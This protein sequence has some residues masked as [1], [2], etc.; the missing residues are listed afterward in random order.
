MSNALASET[1]AQQADRYSTHKVL[2]QAQPA[3]GFNAFSGDVVLRDAIER[4]APWAADRCKALGAIAG[5]ERVQELARLANRHLPELKTHD[6]FGN[7]ID[8]VDFHPSWHE[9]M[10][11]A[12]NHEVPNLAWRTNH[13]NGHFARAVLSYVWNQVEQGTGC[14]TGMAY[15]SYAGFEAE[16]ALAIW[17]EKVKGTEYEFSRKEVGEKPSV[18]IGYAMTEKQGGSD[19]RETQT[20]ARFSHSADYHGKTAH[21]YELT[22]HKWFCSVPQSDGFFTLGK[23]NGEVTCF[24]LP[25]TLPDGSYNRFFVQRLKDKA[26]N[27]SNASSEVEYA[28]TLA[29]RVGEEGKGLREILSHAHLT[30]LDFAV[31]SAG[32]M[33]QSLTLAL[34]HTTTRN[35]FGSTIADRPMMTNVLADMAIEVEAATLMALRVARATDDLDSSE[36]E[37][38]L[39]RV[40][41]PAAKFF[42]CSRAPSIAYEAL[43]CHGGNGF[44]E[45]NPMARLYREAPLN[46]VWEGTANMMCMDVRRAMMK[47]PRT[48]DAL[49]DEVRPHAGQDARFDAMVQH[50]ETLVREAVKDEF[51]ARPMTEAVARVLQGAELLRH[52]AQEV[53]DVFLNTRTPG[54]PGAWGAHY[55]T[56]AI[57]V[58][59]PVAKKIMER[60]RISD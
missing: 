8:W 41:T 13:K 1:L 28:G 14:P 5:D 35:A 19:L 49:F 47:D 10:S 42:N 46:S 17:A 3:T 24:F 21:W 57:K 26:G 59:Q 43:Q 56:L 34:Q 60:A 7:R 15:A 11:I 39:A 58:S 51:F 32:L 29:I 44:I 50:T 52:S 2:N 53:A 48:I 23:V 31:G 36:H 55:G 45:E 38:L 25:R 18:V 4:E 12:W 37:R 30:R 20:T 54:T 33:R 40:A 6:R 27:K 9:L 16:P 22:G